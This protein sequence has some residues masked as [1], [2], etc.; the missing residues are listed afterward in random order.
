VV[1][2]NP[3]GRTRERRVLRSPGTSFGSD[4]ASETLHGISKY[5]WVGILELNMT[6]MVVYTNFRIALNMAYPQSYRT[7]PERVVAWYLEGSCFK[8]ASYLNIALAN[9]FSRNL[10]RGV[11]C[12]N[13]RRPFFQ[14]GV[15]CGLSMDVSVHETSF[16]YKYTLSQY[17]SARLFAYSNLP[18][19]Q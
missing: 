15:G 17:L 2:I 18:F 5:G 12:V 6:Q 11:K 14:I 3:L 1:A 7:A 19:P 9:F 4:R 13:F 10:L 8:N 16:M